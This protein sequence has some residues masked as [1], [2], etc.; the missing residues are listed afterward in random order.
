VARAL[1]ALGFLGGAALIASCNESSRASGT[2]TDKTPPTATIVKTGPDSLTLSTGIVFN[3]GATD[4]LGLKTVT[5]NMTGGYTTQIDSVYRQTTTTTNIPIKID[6][7]KNSPFGGQINIK[8]TVSDGNNNTVIVTDSVFLYNPEALTV[9]LVRPSVGAVTSLGKQMVVQVRAEQRSG[10]K[11]AGYEVTGAFVDS[12][13]TLRGQPL[14]DSLVF[15]DTLNVP[16]TATGTLFTI[17]GFA[18]DS[19]GRRVSAS[20]VSVTIQTVATDVTP[21]IVT[22][23][24]GKRVEARDSIKVTATDPS[25]ILTIGWQGFDL[26]GVIIRGDSIAVGGTLTEATATFSYKFNFA[27][28]PQLV[29]IRAFAIDAANNRGEARIDSL[30]TS[31]FKRDTITVVNGITKPLPKGGRVADAVYNR[32]RNEFY[33]T[34]PNLDRVE[35]FRLVDTT[36]GTG[37][38]VGSHPWG[39]ALWPKDTL[40]N[41]ADTVMVANSGGTNISIVNMLIPRQVR[42]HDLPNFL[43][44]FVSTEIDSKTSLLKILVEEHDFS[45]RPEYLGAT[46]RPTTGLTTC[47][48]DSIYAVYSTTP[49]QDQGVVFPLRGTTRWE[50]LTSAVPQ[51]HFFWEQS[52]VVPSSDADSLQVLVDRGFGPPQIILSAAC[53]VMIDPN[54]LAFRDTTFVRNSGNFTHILIGEGGKTGVDFARAI[55]YDGTSQVTVS[56]CTYTYP[57]PVSVTFTGFI[58]RDLGISPAVKVRDFVSN[59]AVAVHS[60]AVNFNGLTNLIR[61]DSIYVLNNLLRLEGL[62]ASS[63]GNAGMDLNFDHKFDASNAGTPTFGGVLS[64]DSRFVFVA[65]E[66]ANID[67]FD[68]FFYGL[69]ATV[70]IRDPV[71]G[72]LR[73]AKI[74]ATGE[75]VLTGVTTKGVVVVRLPAITN[76]FP[77][78]R[79]GAPSHK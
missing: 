37:V 10:V 62:I 4:N 74:I 65:R 77:A 17:T 35:I 51:S 36:F 48:A 68:S 73:V 38:S 9:V 49:T 16:A 22:F 63:G 79:W 18:E 61:A 30:A 75:Q 26:A 54:Q 67:V 58:E 29:Q 66:D 45:D 78:P 69:V 46:C 70:P 55:A 12:D 15:V 76:T 42:R 27:T 50:N 6:L 52:E 1:R 64:P 20:P 31:P 59:S 11:K 53:G 7:P 56:P 14:P 43:I 25:G 72:P 60:I 41:N 34:N 32:N 5:I 33:L 13:S 3:V 21:P 19:T 57:P 24:E 23:T 44:D 2:E 71:I 28:Y 47:A 39:I 8:V 40:G